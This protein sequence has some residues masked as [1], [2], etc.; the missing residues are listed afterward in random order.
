VETFQRKSLVLLHLATIHSHA[1]AGLI[2]FPIPGWKIFLVALACTMAGGVGTRS[3]YHT[4]T[5]AQTSSLPD[6][7]GPGAVYPDLLC[8]GQRFGDAPLPGRST[9]RV[10]HLHRDICGGRRESPFSLPGVLWA[11]IRCSTSGPPVTWRKRWVQDLDRKRYWIWNYL[12]VPVILL[13]LLG[14]G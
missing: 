14:E 13:S 4:A 5:F 8:R 11:H 10:H 2:L 3:C 1:V 9:I 7:P 12:Q 6:E